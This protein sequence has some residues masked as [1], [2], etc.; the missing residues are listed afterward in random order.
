MLFLLLAVCIIMFSANGLSL[1][2][3]EPEECGYCGDNITW[4]YNP[5]VH[6][7]WI[8]GTGKMDDYSSL[9]QHQ[10]P[11]DPFC[12]NIEYIEI[13]EGIEN[14][15]NYAFYGCNFKQVTLPNTLTSI[16]EYA[17][18]SCNSLMSLEIPDT[19]TEIKTWA[20]A[21]CTSMTS[22]KLPDGLQKIPAELCYGCSSLTDITIPG[23]VTE[24]GKE[25]FCECS[26][27][28]SI[29]I[30]ES[31]TKLG[32]NLYLE[33]SGI[34]GYCSSLENVTLP[35]TLGEI[36][37]RMFEYCTSLKSITIPAG[38][39]S[40][41]KHAFRGC[42][43]LLSIN[44]AAGN[45]YYKSQ[46]GVL[47][48]REMSTLYVYPAGLEYGY[49]VPASVTSIAEYA[50]LECEKLE[51]IKI[52]VELYS[53]HKEA[54]KGCTGLKTIYIP[55]S[56]EYIGDHA[57]EDCTSLEEVI[58]EGGNEWSSSRSVG[59]GAFY[60]CSKLKSIYIPTGF[61]Y[62]SERA[63]GYQTICYWDDLWDD[64]SFDSNVPVEG[65]TISGYAGSDAQT[66]ADENGFTFIAIKSDAKITAKNFTKTYSTK[67]QTFS[68]GAKTTGGKLSYKSS[69]TAIKVTSA[70]K[71]TIKAKYIGK[72]TIT[73][74]SAANANYNKAT[75]KI[76]V[77][78]NPTATT[79][80]TVTNV[81]GKKMKVTW[82]KNTVGKGYQIQYSTSSKF[83][84]NCKTVKITKNSTT[85]KTITGLTKGKTYY[86][87]IRTVYG[88]FYSSWSKAKK[89][90]ISK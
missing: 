64:W 16:G 9:Y 55:E 68:L 32:E 2:A 7:L 3:E 13:S 14:I 5:N 52:P 62:I 51:G 79:L 19:V 54:F 89:V 77:T 17:F 71:V 67:A 61:L 10:A 56:V 22:L 87:R 84:K 82:K 90:K 26:G 47:F 88:S 15:G 11:W 27:L 25:A 45:R 48:N 39:T 85:S 81:S 41:G 46:D 40:V 23:T 72:A 70:G 18:F 75:K 37:P 65:F 43:S 60:N 76:T 49:I 6:K 57:F 1:K 50:F 12:Y 36:Q 42:S 83:S 29:V 86:V 34:F 21:H 78:V 44:V 59:E 53:I 74:T 33:P 24:I 35:S 80:S 66:Y 30:P 58:I 63:F 73:I 38:V 8:E 4:T 28:K 20:F 31:V 69:N